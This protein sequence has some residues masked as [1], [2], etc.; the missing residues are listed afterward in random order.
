MLLDS[1]F[2]VFGMGGERDNSTFLMKNILFFIL[3]W[4]TLQLFL[5]V[6]TP[7]LQ[8]REERILTVITNTHMHLDVEKI[9]AYQHTSCL[10]AQPTGGSHVGEERAAQVRH[11]RRTAAGGKQHS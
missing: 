7:C 10:P 8:R 4:T 9:V 5:K 3:V 11:V 6:S 2:L 1:G